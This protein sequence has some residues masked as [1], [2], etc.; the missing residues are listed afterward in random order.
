LDKVVLKLDYGN[1]V[2]HNLRSTWVQPLTMRPGW[3]LCYEDDIYNR[4]II[5]R[6]RDKSHLIDLQDKLLKEYSEGKKLIRL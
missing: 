1:V 5:Y 2:I 6:S 3:M 4:G